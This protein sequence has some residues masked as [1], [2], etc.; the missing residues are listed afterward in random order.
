MNFVTLVY[1]GRYYNYKECS[2]CEMGLL[3]LFLSSD[4]GFRVAESYKQWA[5][6]DS[7]DTTAGN[8][9][10]LDKIKGYIYLYDLYSEE[11]IPTKLKM[12]CQ[13]FAQL[14]DDWENKVCKQ[15]P[16]EVM[17]KHEN[18]QFTIEAVQ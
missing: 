1:N 9:T 3:G 2:T 4:V 14:M 17:I 11:K 16:T 5:L 6:E 10:S 12:S 8:I 18:D 7:D 15:R 13:Q